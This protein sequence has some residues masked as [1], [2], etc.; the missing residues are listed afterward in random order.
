MFPV[1]PVTEVSRVDIHAHATVFK[2]YFPSHMEN[3][4]DGELVSAEE[5]LVLY[6]RLGIEKGIL[7]PAAGG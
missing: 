3:D 4:P 2:Q 1:N 7:L 5:L 6:D